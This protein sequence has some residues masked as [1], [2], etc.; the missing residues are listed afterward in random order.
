MWAG[1]KKFEAELAEEIRLHRELSGEAAFGSVALTLEE[2]REV[3]G[4]AWLESWKQDIR[5]A[6]RGL[7][8]SPGFALGVIAAI[9]LGIGLNTTMF[10]VFNAY[11]LRPYAVRN[12]YGLYGF[13]W[14]GKNGAGHDFSF[15]RFQELRRRPKVFSDVLATSGFPAELNGRTLYGQAVSTNYSR[16][17]ARAYRKEGRCWKPMT[18]RCW[19]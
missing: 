9:G 5:Y 18:A 7:R 2:S 13:N 17:W 8:R 14:Y 19:C 1:R 16:C 10:T 3:W 11:A 6:L 12:P 4:F 15:E